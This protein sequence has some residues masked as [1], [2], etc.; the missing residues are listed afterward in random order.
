[1]ATYAARSTS[2]TCTAVAGGAAAIAVTTPG[3]STCVDGPLTVIYGTYGRCSMRLTLSRGPVTCNSEA[4]YGGQPRVHSTY[5]MCVYVCMYCVCVCVCVRVCV[6]QARKVS[7]QT[8]GSMRTAV[9]S[10]RFQKARTKRAL[11]DC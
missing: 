3:S 10:A 2:H 11:Q 7:C 1:M 6:K 4:S 9:V 5:P 8:W